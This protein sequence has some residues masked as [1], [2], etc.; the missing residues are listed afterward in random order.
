MRKEVILRIIEILKSN[1][2]LAEEIKYFYFGRPVKA[3]D[4]PFIVVEPAATGGDNISER[5]HGYWKHVF[6]VNVLVYVRNVV[7]EEAEKEALDLAEQAL[8]VVMAGDVSEL[9]KLSGT[10]NIYPVA[11]NPEPPLYEG[12]YSI[13]VQRLTLEA[14]WL[15]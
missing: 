6:R 11:L 13:A 10:F 14:W 12:E 4:W 2:E 3:L 8:S 9:V 5:A 15:E 7:P 1:A